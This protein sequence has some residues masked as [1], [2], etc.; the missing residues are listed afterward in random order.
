MSTF[1]AQ[2]TVIIT[3][4]V[5]ER[6][7]GRGTANYLAAQGWNIGIIDLDDARCKA[8][9]KEIAAEHG[10]QAFGAGANVSDESSV[11]AAI[12]AIEAELPQI[13]AL[14]N[15]AASV[16]RFPT[17]N[18]TPRSGTACSTSTS[19]ASTTPPAA[20]RNPW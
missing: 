13:V 11:R 2:R 4:A 15:V 16:H 9:A 7:I 6:G 17:W 1:P 8:A 5:S 14:A 10:V 18:S 12:D 20:S 19:T 3:G